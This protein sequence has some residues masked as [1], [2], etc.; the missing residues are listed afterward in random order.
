MRVPEAYRSLARPS[1]ALEPSHSPAGTVASCVSD[2]HYPDE[3]GSVGVWIARTYGRHRTP[4]G[5]ARRDRRTLPIRAL[6]G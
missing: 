4:P 3:T 2:V 1:S 6:A 5:A